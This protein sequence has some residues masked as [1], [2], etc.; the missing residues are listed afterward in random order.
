[1]LNDFQNS[2]TGRLG[3]KFATK[4]LH[5][6]VKKIRHAQEVIEAKCHVRLSHSK[7]LSWN[8]CLVKCLLFN[9]VTK[10]RLHW[11]YKK[12]HYRMYTTVVTKKKMLQQ[13]AV[14]DQQ[15]VSH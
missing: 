6:L 14:H 10:R 11:P 4:A 8:I 5:Y 1:M 2:F 7:K 9:S 13:Y 15:S 12:S 3:C